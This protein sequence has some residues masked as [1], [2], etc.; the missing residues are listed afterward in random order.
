MKSTY[1]AYTDDSNGNVISDT[2]RG[3]G[4]IQYDPNNMPIVKSG[5]N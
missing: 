3:I 2:H 1:A 5:E 4:F